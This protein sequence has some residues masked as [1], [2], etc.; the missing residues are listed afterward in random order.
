MA[1][2][3]KCIKDGESILLNMDAVK[4]VRR[5]E[6]ADSED[7]LEDYDGNYYAVSLDEYGCCKIPDSFI[8]DLLE[9]YKN[10]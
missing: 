9:G 3:I 2:F 7:I 4:I 1:Q 8:L 10:Q 5:H 6:R